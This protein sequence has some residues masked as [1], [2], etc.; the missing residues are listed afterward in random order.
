MNF[1]DRRLLFPAVAITA[2]AQQP[3]PE[4]AAAEAT[5]RARAQQ[6]FDLQVA[7]KYRQAESMVADESKDAYYNGNRLN[8]GNYTIEKVEL[9]DGNTKAAV[10]IK[11]KVTL[12]AP[13]VGQF[14]MDAMPKTQWKLQNGEWVYFID[15]DAALE[16]PFGK[17]NPGKG[18]A[19]DSDSPS[20]P[21]LASIMQAVQLDKK[22]VAMAPGQSATVK[23][24]NSL[25]G[26]VDVRLEKFSMRGV[27]A[28]LDKQ[29]LEGGETASVTITA[30]EKALGSETIFV[31]VS[32]L[33]T[34][35]PV[36]ITVSQ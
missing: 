19:G 3:S 4:T 27:S 18:T 28:S 23:V 25:P 13:V 1:F 5:L 33:G 12:M 2:Y 26:P 24:S 16:T 30:S 17:L 21:T 35:L 36:Q 9:S 7:K 14:E 22:S 8:I 6:F 34:H 32:P 20:R 11:S 10:T 31:D 29:H 15:P